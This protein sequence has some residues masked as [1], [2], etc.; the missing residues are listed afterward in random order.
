MSNDRVKVV[1][2]AKRDFFGNGIE[3]RNF[4]PD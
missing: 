2:Y 1:G 4:S 3:Y